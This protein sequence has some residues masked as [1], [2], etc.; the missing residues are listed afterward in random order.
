MNKLNHIAFIMD[1]NGRWGKKKGKSRNFGHLHGVQTVRNIVSACINIKIPFISF[2]VFSTEN[3][4]R[5][6][7]EI[8]YLFNLISIYFLKELRNIIKNNIRINIIGEKN[9]LPNKIKKKLSEVSRKTKM[10][11]RIVINLA[12]NYGAHTEIVNAC[13]K[14]LNKKKPLNNANIRKSLYFN[15]PDPDILI[16]TGGRKRLSNFLL[17]QLAYTELYFLDKLWPDFN[18]NDLIKI[19]KNFKKIKRN[20][21]GI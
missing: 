16:R 21:G 13:K 17:W 11:K 5:P 2:Y 9:N 10:N 15:C 18:K 12:I 7:S 19:I 4:K 3:W 6:K 14:L 1:G 8:N 20:Y